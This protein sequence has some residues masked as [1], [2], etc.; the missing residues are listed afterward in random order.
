MISIDDCKLL[1]AHTPVSPTAR[2]SCLVDCAPAQSKGA[3][4]NGVARVMQ[5]FSLK[6]AGVAGALIAGLLPMSAIAQTARV[7]GEVT[8]YG[9][10]LTGAVAN[11]VDAA[12]NVYVITT[13]GSVYKE[14]LN[15]STGT[16]TEA[17]LFTTASASGSGIAVDSAG[18]NIYVGTGSGHSVVQYT[19]AGTS[20]TSAATFTGFNGAT[21][22]A[23]DASENVYIAD[24]AAGDLYKE[25][26]SG[27]TYTQATIAT[28]LSLPDYIAIDTTGNI[29]VSDTGNTKIYRV[30]GSGTTYVKTALTIG[31]L[32]AINGIG[33]DASDD[34]YI[35]TSTGVVEAVLSGGAYASA[36]YYQYT[37]QALTLDSVGN[38]Y[39]SSSVQSSG[40]KLTVGSGY[41]NFGSV[42]PGAPATMTV[43]FTLTSGGTLGTP[44]VVTQG[45]TGFDFTSGTG[46]T[47]AGAVLLTGDSCTVNIQFSP[48]ASG[49]RLGAVNLTNGS[50]NTITSGFLG[51]IGLAPLAVYHSTTLLSTISTTLSQGRGLTVDPAGNIFVA[52]STANQILKFPANSSTPIILVANTGTCSPVGT[53]VDGVGNV[54]YTCNGSLNIYEVVGGSGMPV[55][56]P[57]GYT[58]DDHL[59][60][61]A[62]GNLYPTSYQPSNLFLKVAAGTHAVTTIASA[63]TGARFVGAVTD[64]SG[65]TFAPDYTNGILYE[66]PAG[67]NSLVTLYSGSPLQAPHAIAEDAAGDLYVSNTTPGSSGAGTSNILEFS[68]NNYSA[69]PAAIAVPGSDS[70]AISANGDF[71][72]IYNN[73]NLAIYS[74][75]IFALTYTN[76]P[77]GQTSSPQT[78]TLENDGTAPLTFSAPSSGTNPS[79]STNFIF[80]PASTCPELAR[81]SA[82]STLAAGA[83]CTDVIDFLPQQAGSI[84][85]ALITTDNSANVAGSTQS[86]DVTGTASQGTPTVSVTTASATLGQSVTL[87]ATVSGGG[88][89]P[90]GGV[91]FV[92]G[93]GVTVTAVCTAG[94]GSEACTATYPTT[95]LTAGANTI[96]ATVAA[97][98][99]YLSATGTGTLTLAQA[100]TTST[101]ISSLNPSTFG[102]AVTFTGTV[103]ST[104]ET[105]S[106]TVTFYTGSTVL[107]TATLGNNGTASFTTSTLAVGTDPITISYGGATNYATSTSVVL[108]QMVNKAAGS[109]VLTSSNVAPSF[110]A[111]VT[112]TD[113]LAVIN[114]VA[115]TGT[116]TFLDGATTLGTGTISASG[117]ATLTITTL[118]VG[119]DRV[120]ASFPGD[121]N[122]NSSTSAA[123]TETVSKAAGYANALTTSNA[124]PTFGASITLTDTLPVLGNVAPTGSVTFYNGATVLGTGTLNASGIAT[125]A[126]AALPV[127]SDSVTAGYNGDNNYSSSTSNAVAETVAKAAL[128]SDVLTTS[129]A[130]PTFGGSITITD[131]LGAIGGTYPTG[132][133]TFY[134]GVTVL[135]TGTISASGVATLSTA[136]LPTGSDSV[137]AVYGGDSNFNNATSNAV[138]ETVAKVNVASDILTTSNA[139]PT[140]GGSVTLTDTFGAVAGTYPTGSVVFYSGTTALGTGTVS[141]SGVAT[142]TTSAL[143]TGSDSVSAVYGG[144]TNF[145]NATSNTVTEAV[146]KATV[147]SDVLTSSNATPAF[148]NSVTLTDTVAPVNGTYPSGSVTFYNGATALG[149]GTISASG[150]ATLTT[151]ALPPG[152]DA[153]TAHYAGDSNFSAIVSN[154]L[155]EIVAK[156]TGYGDV[157]TTSSGAPS[158][159]SSVI[160]TDTIAA[161]NGTYPT[162]SVTFYNGTT[163][164]GTGMISASGVAT[165]STSALP[166][167]TD[168][169][170]AG[171]TG[172]SNFGAAT[173]NAVTETVSKVSVASDVL[174]T[175]NAAPSLG[176]SVTLTDTLGAVGGSYP[177]GTITFYRGTT[178]LGTGM[179]SASGVA[180]LST[181]ALP[182]GSDSVTAVY[183]GDTNFSNA[184][185]NAITENV[186]KATGYSDIL[187]TSNASPAFGGSITLT[188]TIAAV[189]GT[190]PTGSVTFYNGA[191]A[192]GTGTISA[193]GVATLSTGAL[194]AGSDSVTAVYG[195]DTNFSNETS[196]AVTETVAKA[197]GYSDV[198]TT[199]NASPGFGGSVTLTDTLAAVDGTYPTGSVTFYNG[200]TALGTGTIS[201]SGIASLSTTALPV[202]SDTITATYGGDTN[203]SNATSNAVTENVAKAGGYSNALTSSNANPTFGN[204]VV[205]TDTLAAVN[206]TYPT[207]IVTFYYGTTALGTGT[208]SASGVASLPTTTL[209]VGADSITATYGGDNNFSGSSSNALIENV[210]KVSVP[211]DVLTTSNA[212]PAFGASITLTDTLGAVAG[213]YP[214]GMVT[215]YS[216]TTVLGTGTLSASGVATL[217]TDLATGSDSVTAVYG[218]N[219]TFSTATSNAVAEVVS[220]ASGSNTLT[221]SNPSPAIGGS[222]TLT[223]T[224]FSVGGVTPTGTVTFYNGAA[225]LGTGSVNSSGIA[226]LLA[227]ALPVGTSS[228]TAVYGGDTN[229]NT[230]T[231]NAVVE[232]VNKASGYSDVLSA[233]TT[234]PT[235]GQS[236]TL[237]DTLA[238]VNGIAPTGTVTFFNGV[239]ALGTG[240]INGSGVATLTTS[241]LPTGTDTVTAVYGGDANFSNETSNIVAVTVAKVPATSNDTAT[242]AGTYGSPATPVT[243][244][245]PYAGATAPAGAITVTDTHG[246]TATVQA[247]LCTSGGGSLTCTISLATANEPAGSNSVTV[248]QAGDANYSGSTGSGTLN[249][250]KVAATNN[251]TLTGSGTYGASTSPVTV[252]IPY[253][254][255][256]APTGAISLADGHGDAI[257]IPASSCAASGGTLTCTAN[258]PTLNEV[259]GANSVTVNQA[260]DANYS[261]STGSG[262]VTLGKAA[263]T[264]NDTATGTGTYGTST[265]AVTVTIPYAGT[266]APT[267]AITLTDAHGNTVT[268]Q[269]SSCAASNGTLSCTANLPTATEVIGANSVTITQAADANYSGS[270]GSGTVTIGKASTANDDSA[271]GTGSFGA[272]TTAVRVTIP[273][274]GVTAPT[275]AVTVSDSHNNTITVQASS[276]TAAA[277]VLTCTANLPTATEPVGSNPVTV[278]QVADANYSG[279]TGSGF[280]S[281]GKAASTSNDSATG[282]GT[283][284]TATTPVTVSIPYVGTAAPTGAITVTDTHGN[285]VSASGSS[286]TASGSTLSC[287]V[288]L[289]TATEPVGSNSVTID[290][291]GDAN[292]SGSTGSGTVTIGKAPATTTD[293]ATGTGSFGAA[294]TSVVV[295]IPYAGATAPTGAITVTDTH[296]N[297]ATVQ[298]SSCVTSGGALTCTANLPTANEPVGSNSITIAQAGDTNYS[299]ST[300]TGTITINPAGSSDDDSATGTGSYGAPTIPLT[301]VIPYTGSVPPTGTIAV[302]DAFGNTVSI[303]ASSCKASGSSLVCAASL[304]IANEPVGTNPITVTQAADANHAASTGTGTVTLNK[305]APTTSDTAMGSGTYGAATTP[306]TVTIPYA[307]AIAPTGA[308][309]VTDGLGNT[310][311]VPATACSAAAG[312]LICSLNLPSANEPVGPNQVT[313]AQVGD[314]NYSGS[315]GSGTVTIAAAVVSPVSSTSGGVQNVTITQGT[316]STLLTAVLSY[317]GSTAP[318]GAVSFTIAGNAPVTATCNAVLSPEICTATYDTGSLQVGTYTITASE[319]ADADYGA[320]SATGTL[321]VAAIGSVSP[322]LETTSSVD[323]VLI[324][325]GAPTATFTASIIYDGP[326]PTGAVTFTL[327]GG[328]PVTATCTATA[329][330]LTC[331]A[332]YPATSL[333]VGTYVIT[334]TEAAD[335]NY[336]Q[337]SATGILTVEASAASPTSPVLTTGSNVSS[338]LVPYGTVSANLTATIVYS[339]PAPTGAVT[340][341][342]IANSNLTVPATCTTGPSPIT[343]TAVYPT[344]TLGVGGYRIQANEAAD[345][346]YPAGS[347]VGTLTV[348]AAAVTSSATVTGT[349]TYGSATTSVTVTISYSGSTAP[350]GAITVTDSLGNTATVPASSCAVASGAL[351]CQANLPTANVPAGTDAVTVSQASDPNYGGSSGSGSITMGKAP[352]TSTDT[353]TGNGSYGAA[354]TP[355]T[356]SIPY[357]G[358]LAPTGAITLSDSFGDTISVPASSCTAVSGVLN[359]VANLP[360]ANEPLGSNPVLVTQAADANYSGSTGSGAVTIGKAAGGTDSATGT[361]SYGAATTAVSVT[362]PYTGSAYPTGVITLADTHGNTVSVPAS[363]CTAAAGVLTCSANLPTAS[364]PVGAN[365]ITVNQAAD[366]DHTASAGSGTVT[367][368]KAAATSADTLTGTGTY[369]AS[370]TPVTVTIPYAGA[371]APTGAITVSDSLGD[372]LT[373]AAS[374]CTAANGLLTCTGNL[375]SANDPV[376]TT[377]ITV[378]QA[379]DANYSGSTGSGSITIGKAAGG[380]DTATGTGT[381]GGATTAV[382]VSIPFVGSTAPT[383]AITLTDTHGNT[384]TVQASTCTAAKGALSCTVNLPTVNEP[385]GS[386]AV[387]VSQV[388]DAVFGASTGAG[389][390]TINKA[391]ATSSDTVTGTGTYGTA[392]TPVTVSIPF[393]GA[394]APSGAITVADAHGNTV[395]IQASSCTAAAGVLTCTANLPTANEPIGTNTVTV[396][397]AADANYSGSTGSGSVSIGKTIPTLAAP[398]ISPLNATFGTPVTLTQTVPAGETGTVTFYSGTTV[399]GTATIAN[400]VAVLTTSALPAG[401]DSITA[402]AGGDGNYNAATSPAVVDTVNSGATKVALASSQSNVIYGS[403]VSFTATVS[404]TPASTITGTVTFYDGTTAI[405]TA[406]AANGVG[407]LSL[408]TLG[409]GTHVIT[410]TFTP[411]AGSPLSAATSPAITETV[412]GAASS[413][414]LTSSLNPGIAGQ[415]I[416]FSA[417][418]PTTVGSTAPTGMVTFYDG[419]TVIGTTQLNAS[420]VAN[421]V[422]SALSGGVHNITAV[423]AGDS[424]YATST[425]GPVAQQIS[426]YVVGNTTPTLTVDP[427]KTAAFNITIN[428]SAGV[429]FGSPVVLTVTGLPANFTSGFSAGT[430]M[431]GTGGA[432]STMS[433]QTFAQVVAALEQKQHM[434][435]YE[436]AAF[437]A[438][439]LPL[440]GMRRVRRRLPKAMLMLAICV[441]SFG[442]IAPLTGCGGGYFGPAPASYTLTVTGTSGA[443]QHSTTVTLNVN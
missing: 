405:G 61:D 135:G 280:I 177:T 311:T 153:I 351:T 438:F 106:G 252:T 274:T 28:G 236:V 38:I 360:T 48:E 294:S 75:A 216:G 386:N 266:V 182:T 371:A 260:A 142:L 329:S 118:P 89:A 204:S 147:P 14:S 319:A 162:G 403:N 173:S 215:F 22:P 78:V 157:L 11:A 419:T 103:S 206:G 363:S 128:A 358:S 306:V 149:T 179:I 261:G 309:S 353:A 33:V 368:N 335:Q 183:G 354:T 355:V 416:T 112:F 240:A 209:P 212:A 15:S 39:L 150:V 377:S 282:T 132:T 264:T 367:I 133:V 213:T 251:D 442:V 52:N 385:V 214:A 310:A 425:S 313:I 257:T 267:G 172:D 369:G 233:S 250:G 176:S 27:T 120:T 34:L 381:Y 350:T 127:G 70:I 152:T 187:T 244:T 171:Y 317:T 239:T 129:N 401:T 178:A 327:P 397:Q 364:E 108:N 7:A 193:S 201:A 343:C 342:V 72:T 235:F 18:A 190:F 411:A 40:T 84:S 71:Y 331:T 86:V 232:T 77:V 109:N 347:A 247:S 413:V 346:N 312:T 287:T 46:G 288:N 9:S 402:M 374:S 225:A 338:V 231:S 137:T 99:N 67:T 283:Y 95:G 285:T 160:L 94:T 123:V 439:L 426:D 388:A 4:A 228:I 164:L 174:T 195:G 92:V 243:V 393:A 47:C 292:Y 111:S 248:S 37:G 211:S 170:T 101:L 392:T 308:V 255:P 299:G 333:G 325:A 272:A 115:P 202:G 399:L 158:F 196:N 154:T 277:N 8:S 269:A 76:T 83:S 427:G 349:G 258:F 262:A 24:E 5:R 205:L 218:G 167:G 1:H 3:L 384:V 45:L 437:W 387:N 229:Y 122:Y 134:N 200:M 241:T 6:Q 139:A 305:A 407:S 373:L 394:A 210:S 184:T 63:P 273:Y 227:G 185:S 64:A 224:L 316:A 421:F 365:A 166:T 82:P 19:G 326:I 220:K 286:C 65:N 344:A 376:G 36:P 66:L 53:A 323:S 68:A 175:S 379:G 29:F 25:T 284:G 259:V 191:T 12:Q 289:P 87:T 417:T 156:A 223:D 415:S 420:G 121:S 433:V 276:C 93:S 400:G 56:I 148:G 42:G 21:A 90:T 226:T 88:V 318:S 194:P 85:G 20:Y 322:V 151:S 290:Q 380:A 146:A 113:T 60:V 30:S 424:N 23:V 181:T 330:P 340:F 116:V 389:T 144:D 362:I 26:L 298:A 361:G 431:P 300:G 207:G 246:N 234:S 41:L 13:A 51:G 237:S 114:S 332:T 203:F 321:T 17:F 434:K 418:V 296:G 352:A 281:I 406:T 96:T 238:T 217:S 161:V 91:T 49:S 10:S 334:A 341:T 159:G 345:A 410:A 404:T 372:T 409:V 307:G 414:V 304:P 302:S 57:V 138:A 265:T 199:S 422:T 140:F 436:A 124:S 256:T 110:G 2:P 230:S 441:A 188:D 81:S 186:A 100:S 119:S 58:T 222:V 219:A 337:G 59:S 102:T 98:D 253:S 145:N 366:A 295:T 208:I 197:T 69:T 16:Y 428:P 378:S 31:G 268:V 391:L 104:Y 429:S 141:A 291:A 320:G 370:T 221:T 105:P 279:S 117:V 440:L 396:S 80:D 324:T 249:I 55:A 263:A 79:I 432:T 382:T 395:T 383:G 97:D 180:T 275:G 314:A 155:T 254:G 189:N 390:V 50:G 315:T 43:A 44:T 242:G 435:S 165:F 356:V 271:T 408:S 245:I 192:L 423:Y 430:V 339:G 35:H 348:T 125:L 169:V 32:T 163:A 198:L 328:T 270:T 357:A 130:A 398:S 54:Y 443:L 136:A 336:P 74:R 412:G 278:S 359:C 62:A 297:T 143:P 131:T 73:A 301:V 303:A 107:G 126:T 375:P 293:T 168:S